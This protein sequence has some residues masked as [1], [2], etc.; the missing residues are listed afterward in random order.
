MLSIFKTFVSRENQYI[1][2][3]HSLLVCV[4]LLKDVYSRKSAIETRYVT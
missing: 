2:E 4:K 3:I 1:P